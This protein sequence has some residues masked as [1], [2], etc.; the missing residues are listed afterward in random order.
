MLFYST[1]QPTEF[2]MK[3]I[4]ATLALTIASAAGIAGVNARPER[5]M[6]V[7][8]G[9]RAEATE[10]AGRIAE[11]A[12]SLGHNR[13]RV[14]GQDVFIPLDEA[15]LSFMREGDSMVMHVAVESEYRFARANRQA[16]LLALKAKGEEILTLARK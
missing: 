3:I 1:S 14:Y 9:T 10:L 15:T 5:E 12:R 4:V 6:S 16:A 2:L 11:A 13:V 8:V 7:V